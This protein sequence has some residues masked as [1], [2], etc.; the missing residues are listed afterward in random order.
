[1]PTFRRPRTHARNAKRAWCDPCF[2]R[3]AERRL[4]HKA[5]I[6]RRTAPTHIVRIMPP[7]IILPP[8]P[9]PPAWDIDDQD[10]EAIMLAIDETVLQ[11]TQPPPS[12]PAWDKVN[13]D[14]EA[15]MMAI[16]E[17]AFQPPPSP[18]P[19][20]TI[21]WQAPVHPPIPRCFYADDGQQPST[22]RQRD[23][24]VPPQRPATNLCIP[25][26]PGCFYADDGQQPSTSGQGLVTGQMS[27]PS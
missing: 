19:Q 13:Q 22:S 8:P 3:R 12:P 6:Q 24:M 7:S 21:P 1:M 9:S 27:S 16:D 26:Q 14:I 4:Q 23:M 15:L 5:T 18:P 25:R 20:P 2:R 17:T 10:I 11:P